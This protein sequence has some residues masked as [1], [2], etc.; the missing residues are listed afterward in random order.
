[1][2]NT[3]NVVYLPKIEKQSI[4]YEGGGLAM[5]KGARYEGEKSYYEEDGSS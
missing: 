1:M 3:V 4:Y 2:I 5:H